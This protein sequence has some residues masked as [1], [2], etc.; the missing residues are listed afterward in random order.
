M[1]AGAVGI[2]EH[3]LSTDAVR[4]YKPDP[5]AYRMAIEALRLTRKEILFVASASWD[6]DGAKSFGYTTFWV[7]RRTLPPE[8]L[9]VAPDASGSS[10]A[11]LVRFVKV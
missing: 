10:L 2:F 1:R 3:V 7:N 5:R 11:D 8:E 4:T 6:A 9:G